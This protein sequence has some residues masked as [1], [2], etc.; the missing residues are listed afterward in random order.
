MADDADALEEQRAQLRD[1][2]KTDA[3]PRV[4]RRA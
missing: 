3:D 4:Q 2:T 1:L